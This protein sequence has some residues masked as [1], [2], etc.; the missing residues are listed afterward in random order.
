MTED[1]L[2][3]WFKNLKVY[4]SLFDAIGAYNPA[5]NYAGPE[6]SKTLSFFI[7]RKL[8][9]IDCNLCFYHHDGLY[10]IG[11]TKKDRFAADG[12]MVL[13]AL[14][15]I[16]K[17]PDRWYMYGVNWLRKHWA[18]ERL[19]KYFEAVRAGGKSSFTF[20]D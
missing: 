6:N 20:I 18:R 11:G 10:E 12:A 19:I 2:I 9:G 4:K 7:P 15:I 5:L 3:D 8:W 17:T 13:T 1:E 14:F 16:E